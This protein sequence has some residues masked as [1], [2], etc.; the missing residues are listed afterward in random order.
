MICAHAALSG[1]QITQTPYIL[2]SFLLC[3]HSEA[4]VSRKAVKEF[5]VVAHRSLRLLLLMC[6]LCITADS[7]QCHVQIISLW[8]DAEEEEV[9]GG[10]QAVRNASLLRISAASLISLLIPSSTELFLLLLSSRDGERCKLIWRN[11]QNSDTHG[12]NLDEVIV[13]RASILLSTLK[14]ETL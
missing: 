1:P 6:G 14:G 4:L 2:H 12:K 3:S 10:N 9:W 5:P 7:H 8:T 13:L 11:T